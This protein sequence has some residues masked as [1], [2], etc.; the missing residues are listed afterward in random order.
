MHG[1]GS[2]EAH[3]PLQRPRFPP[4]RCRRQRGEADP[5]LNAM[6]PLLKTAALIPTAVILASSLR[7]AAATT[8]AIAAKDLQFFESKIR[9][10]LVDKC[11]KCHSKDADKIRGGLILDTREGMMHGGNTGPAIEPGN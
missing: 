11:Y 8:P 2:H 10:L 3:L 4:D 6:K 9:P 7:A 1:H 5:R